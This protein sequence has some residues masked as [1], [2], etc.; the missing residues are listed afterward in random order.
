MTEQEQEPEK[1]TDEQIRRSAPYENWKTI[2]EHFETWAEKFGAS[3]GQQAHEIPEI[4]RYLY[5]FN[6]LRAKHASGN[7]LEQLIRDKYP[8]FAMIER[9]K[10]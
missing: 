6:I 9:L 4:L 1:M 5:S 8:G 2:A 10:A 7:A 3:D